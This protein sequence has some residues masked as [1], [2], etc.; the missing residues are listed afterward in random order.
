MSKS[1]FNA[2]K[3]LNQ[4]YPG[5]TCPKIVLYKYHLLINFKVVYK[6]KEIL[7]QVFWCSHDFPKFTCIPY[8]SR[9]SKIYNFYVPKRIYAA[10]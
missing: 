4:I 2:L 7:T 9:H 3:Y 10:Q 5:V 1:N 8:F 6:I